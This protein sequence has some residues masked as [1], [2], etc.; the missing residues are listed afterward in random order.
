MG[1][2]INYFMHP[3]DEA[4]FINFIKSTADICFITRP[5]RGPNLEILDSIS[6][7]SLQGHWGSV[8]ILWNRY[9]SDVKIDLIEEGHWHI[10]T[11]SPLIEFGLCYYDKV[12]LRRDR[13]YFIT[14]YYNEDSELI[15]MPEE[16]LKWGSRIISWIRKNYSKDPI[17]G[18]Y[19]SPA[20]ADF[21]ASGGILK[22]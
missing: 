5:Q 17:T 6:S 20:A 11:N 14:S 16:F 9:R 7:A 21:K 4:E 8:Y 13:L 10:N 22:E 12:I 15:K 2:Q 3:D 18:F 19:M 1:R